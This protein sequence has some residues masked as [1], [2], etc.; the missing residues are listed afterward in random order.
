[1]ASLVS[2]SNGLREIQFTDTDGIRK[3][4]RLGKM[5]LKDAQLVLTQVELMRAAKA[6]NSALKPQ[7]IEWMKTIDQT[8]HQR[9]ARVGL[10][11][12]RKTAVL[13]EYLTGYIQRRVDAKPGTV[14][15]WRATEVQLKSFFGAGRDLRTITQGDADAFRLS[16]MASKTKRG[17][18]QPNTV[19]KHLRVARLFFNAA[20]RDEVISK[21]PFNGVD[22]SDRRNSAREYFV[23]RKEADACIEAAPDLQWRLIIALARYAGLRTP[24]ELVRLRW[25]D[26][27]WD[28][29]RIVVHSPKTE[30]YEGKDTRIIP[31]YP[32]LKQLLREGWETEADASEFVITRYRCDS[33][34]LRTTLLKIIE[35]AGLKPWPK[36]FQN[37]RASRQ[38]EL[39]ESFPTHVV[40]RWMGNS[41]K[42]A[43]KHYL[44]V[45]D[46]HFTKAQQKAQQQTAATL[47]ITA[48]PAALPTKKPL[49]IPDFQGSDEDSINPARTRTWKN[50]TK[51]CCVTI[52][53][54]GYWG[55]GTPEDRLL[56]ADQ[57]FR[58][59]MLISPSFWR[60][61]FSEVTPKLRLAR[62]SSG[63]RETS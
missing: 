14:L 44:Q 47:G 56:F 55:P 53:L 23:S 12:A 48:Q 17:V 1:M 21:N 45:T 39:E 59:R 33:Q 30:G 20:I 19:S 2:R 41:P 61:S 60:I 22:S 46:D 18:M 26:I 54:P 11:E 36:L 57:S 25:Q 15:K 5:S 42:V 3:A 13:G 28:S 50:R 4:V 52:T 51:I 58:S 27:L 35:R 34:N 16:L 6:L 62:S 29:D 10:I 49:E 43:Q 9:L 37:L 63:V 24:S 40:C 8:L 31:L 7:T 32:E 38:T